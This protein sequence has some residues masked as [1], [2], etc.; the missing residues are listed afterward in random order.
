LRDMQS[1]TPGSPTL[2][3]FCGTLLPPP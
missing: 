2:D 1:G 3:I